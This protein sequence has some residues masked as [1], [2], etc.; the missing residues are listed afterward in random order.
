[1][2]PKAAQP[3]LS[4]LRHL[5]QS[6]AAWARGIALDSARPGYASTLR[7]NLFLRTL[8]RETEAEFCSADGGELEDTPKRPAKMRSLISSSA[9]AVNFFDSWRDSSAEGLG[10]ALGLGASLAS[11]RFEYKPARYPVGPRSPNFDLLLSL[12]GGHKVAVESKFAEPFRA[13]GEDALLSPKYFP[14]GVDLWDRAGLGRA[15]QLAGRLTAR[16]HYLDAAQLLKHM[17][18]LAS[19]S[20]DSSTL[21]YLWYDTGLDDAREHRREVAMFADQVAGD[22][23]GF[24][25]RSYQE[26]LA[27]LPN[28]VEPLAGWR[29]YVSTRYFR[30][31]S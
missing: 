4:S 23:V 16:W 8:R 28:G 29:G 15:Q 2:N 24:V 1:V 3:I 19:E 14:N 21:L 5:E 17:L 12:N 9:L 20:E 30:T 27:A 31:I 25:S 13:P 22:R 26:A 11:L 18:G 7:D 6:Q 10:P